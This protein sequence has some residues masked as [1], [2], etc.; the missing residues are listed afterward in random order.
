MALLRKKHGFGILSALVVTACSHVAHAASAEGN[1]T[2][3]SV[4]QPHVDTSWAASVR[5]ALA[6]QAGER[7]SSVR[8][9]LQHGMASWYGGRIGHHRTASGHA[10]DPSALTAA[11]PSAPLGS[12]LLVRSEETGQ[13]VVVTVNDRGPYSRGRIIDL[14]HE[15]ARQLGMLGRGVAHVTVSPLVSGGDVE[16]AQAPDDSGR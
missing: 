8:S 15:A 5:E 12:K 13:S 10:F 11:H 1:F 4:T 6:R 3:D 9:R 16:V 14:S 2:P 7:I